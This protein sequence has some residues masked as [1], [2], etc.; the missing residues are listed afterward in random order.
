MRISVVVAG[1]FQYRSSAGR[2]LMTPGSLLLGNPG[3]LFECAHNHGEGDRC[4]SFK[5]SR[6][7]FERIAADLGC[8]PAKASFRVPRLP[9]A[10]TLSPLVLRS[11]AGVAGTMEPA[12]EELVL[13]I[14]SL[15]GG[16]RSDS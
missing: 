1:S 13:Q 3:D 2:A 10:R 7:Y 6:D 16:R 15:G 4:V 14:G 8:R 11:C 5:Y 12:W 9:A